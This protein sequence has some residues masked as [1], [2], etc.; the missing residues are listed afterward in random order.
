MKIRSRNL[1]AS[2]MD[3]KPDIFVGQFPIVKRF[4]YHF[5]Y[6]QELSRAYKESR[7]ASSFWTHT[8]DAHLLQAAIQWC[9]VFGAGGSN[10]THWKHLSKENV[11][12]LQYS[13]REDLPTHV[14]ITYPGFQQY[15]KEMRDFRDTYAAHRDLRYQKA[16]PHFS[17]ALT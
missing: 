2:G 1:S 14:G 11:E 10:P 8:I 9:M 3:Y 7:L 5:V 16:V 6:Y 12:E 15:W 17:I 13:F 4:V